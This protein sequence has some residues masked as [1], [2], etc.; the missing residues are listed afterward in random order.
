MYVF[1]VAQLN[2]YLKELLEC[3]P[4]LQSVWVQGEVSNCSL[5]PA[6]HLY[7]T[8]KDSRSQ[9]RCVAFRSQIGRRGLR[10]PNNG[11]A[12]VVH[13]RVSIYEVQGSYQ[14]YVDLIQPEG[15]GL[16]HLRFE[17]LRARLEAEGLFDP[18]RKRPL[19]AFP[20]R[21]GV[22]TSP[23]GAVIRDIISIL[24]RRYP[25]A[26]LVLAPANVQGDGAA[27]S[28]C[29]ALQAL[30]ECGEVDVIIVARGGGSLEELWAFNEERVAR[31]I[32]ASKVPVVS[33]VGHETDYTI[34]DL[35][36]DVRAPTPSAAAELVSPDC[37]ECEAQVRR[38]QEQLIGLALAQVEDRRAGLERAVANLRRAS[39]ANTLARSRQRVDDLARTAAYSV[40]SL[41]ALHRERVNGQEM[42]L[43][44]LNPMAVLRRG[45]SICWH[46]ASGRIITSISHVSSR[47]ALRLQVS[48]GS[49]TA[50]AD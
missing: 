21:V 7:F 41:L 34:A 49:F 24:Q 31:A 25:L 37:R 1:S 2:G 9:I 39:P 22:V 32:Y 11:E 38:C 3:D 26:E 6:G 28:I 35:A 18:A 20:K 19:P 23:T 33:G 4:V 46:Q 47:D 45:Y 12:V 48:D 42:R 13:G 14:L 50:T 15:V 43:G 36:A 30:N 29:L 17:E 16:L 27:D 44:S 40:R 8:L 5:S 10:V